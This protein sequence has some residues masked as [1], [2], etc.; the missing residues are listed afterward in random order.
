MPYRAII[1]LLS[2]CL[3][4][5][6][7]QG[8]ISWANYSLPSATIQYEQYGS[9]AYGDGKVRPMDR[10]TQVAIYNDSSWSWD[11]ATQTLT[12]LSFNGLAAGSRDCTNGL[13]WTA[14][15]AYNHTGTSN[16]Y[17]TDPLG[18]LQRV[19]T[20]GT[21]G[22]SG[23]PTWNDAGGTTT[24][25]TVVWTD[26]GIQ[27]PPR[28]PTGQFWHDR[29]RHA[30]YV[31]GGVCD[32]HDPE[33]PSTFNLWKQSTA[34]GAWTPINTVHTPFTILGG[35]WQGAS[36][37]FDYDDNI[38]VQWGGL[39]GGGA[40]VMVYCPTD[41]NAVPGT[42]TAAQTAAG[43]VADDWHRVTF[44]G[45]PPSAKVQPGFQYIQ[46]GFAV[47]FGGVSNFGANSGIMETWKYDIIA[48]KFT[49]LSS[50]APTA[51]PYLTSLFI[52]GQS[53]VAYDAANGLLYYYDIIN[54]HFWTLDPI[55]GNGVWRDQGLQSNGPICNQSTG[56]QCSQKMVYDD[57]NNALVLETYATVVGSANSEMW[58]AKLAPFIAGL[59]AST[60]A[61]LDKDGDGYGVGPLKTGPFTD[62][63][64]DATT[65]TKVTSASYTFVAADV[66]RFIDIKAGLTVGHYQILSVAAGAATL[67]SS[68]GA[69]GS[70]GGTWVIGGCL[71][72]DSDD[73]DATVHTK[74]QAVT[75]HATLN[76]FFNYQGYY[77]LKYWI[78]DSANGNDGTGQSCTPTNL[79]T[80]GGSDCLPYQNWTA[81]QSSTAAGDAVLFRGGTYTYPVNN[82]AQTQGTAGVPFYL[83]GY[84]GET[85]RFSGNPNT[86]VLQGMSYM[87]VDGFSFDHTSSGGCLN[88]GTNDAGGN[89]TVTTFHNNVVRHINAWGCTWG[90]HFFEWLVDDELSENYLHDND[91]SGSAQHGAYLGSSDHPS[92]NVVV[93]RNIFAY[94]DFYGDQFNGRVTYLYT[95][96]NVSFGNMNGGFSWLEGISNSFFR[97]NVA[98]N[99]G[100]PGL[101]ISNYDGNEGTNACG[102]NGSLCVCGTNQQQSVCAYDQK[103]NLIENFTN[104]L[105]RYDRNG[106]GSC[107]GN[108]QCLA[109]IS[110]GYQSLCTTATCKATSFSGNVFRNLIL[111][112]Y[113]YANHYAPIRYQDNVGFANACASGCMAW[114]SATRFDSIVYQQNDGSNGTGVFGLCPTGGSIN[115]NS[116]TGF[117]FQPYTCSQASAI[118]NLSGCVNA[119]P[120]FVA[121]SNVY[122]GTP[123]LFDLR[124]LSTSPAYH[125]GTPSSVPLFDL[126]ASPFSTSAPSL[127]AYDASAGTPSVTVTPATSSRGVVV[128]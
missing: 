56:A 14:S 59:G 63:A 94:N 83:L 43:C 106:D 18:H 97:N 79:D 112:N 58:V 54:Q 52:T 11:T 100:Q 5:Q 78:L 12:R 114:L 38:A 19:T 42:L 85:A 120:K 86:I 45:G 7:P 103:D 65:N 80:G 102:G 25:G 30:L 64:I 39:A 68:P 91:G 8:P 107:S 105:G 35:I 47:G 104:Y 118:T 98:F 109:A 72:P 75:A 128:Q 13:A 17:L 123:W 90:I 3:L 99:N 34:T 101:V 92:K 89:P 1:L 32:S 53:M 26:M 96:Q 69:T 6:G 15:T 33:T 36:T 55:N 117:G 115:C 77:P 127:G 62:L 48:Q 60:Y 87:V 22:S 73:N 27:P 44:T 116:G 95:D 23:P 37:V 21:S 124:L 93:R 126:L 67:R 24:D 2:P 108:A 121:A 50:G 20:E 31:M 46:A 119:D 113:G 9:L 4:A 66:N 81:I 70:T 57:I 28:H 125:S 16:M 41:L 10:V 76:G 122:Y 74:A 61:C 82:T 111:D 51:A 110:I 49:E 40:I 84:P 88:G 71:G 29:N